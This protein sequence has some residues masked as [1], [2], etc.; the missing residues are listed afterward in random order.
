[1]SPAEYFEILNQ[2]RDGLNLEGSVFITLLF[3]YVVVT[4]LVGEKLS[5]FQVWALSTVYTV[6]LLLP[7]GGMISRVIGFQTLANK[8][9]QEYP[10]YAISFIAHSFPHFHYIV[11]GVLVST[12][13]L[14]IYFMIHV[15]L[16]IGS[17]DKVA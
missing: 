2:L 5:T 8:F 6:F 16:G 7:F 12:W 1:M 15:R 17:K 14:S 9:H 11:G 10:E 4:Y 3:A 13:L